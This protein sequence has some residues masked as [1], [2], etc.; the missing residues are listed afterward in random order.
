MSNNNIHFFFRRTD[1]VDFLIPFHSHKCYE[2]VYYFAGK[3]VCYIDGR[4]F[5]YEANDCVIVPPNASHNDIHS[6][7]SSMICIGFTIDHDDGDLPALVHADKADS[8][9]PLLERIDGEIAQ[10]PENFIA[11]VNALMEIIIIELKR[12]DHHAAP[13]PSQRAMLDNAINYINEYYLTDISV[14]QLADMSNYSYHRFRHIFQQ[15]M[16]VSPKQYVLSKRLDYAK[17]LLADNRDSITDVCYKC[18]FSSTS[19]F[20]R[21]FKKET[22]VTPLQYRKMLHSRVLFSEQ[23]T[24]YEEGPPDRGNP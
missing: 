18:G 11:V 12:G 24:Q 5:P 10:K 6:E 15:Q 17:T 22:D 7:T 4:E 19:F 20:I 21:Q 13:S 8:I 1:P 2:L 23:Q 9:R 14:Q 3:G 16:G